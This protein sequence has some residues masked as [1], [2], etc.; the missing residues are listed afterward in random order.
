MEMDMNEAEKVDETS[1]GGLMV[2]GKVRTPCTLITIN[3]EG[4]VFDIYVMPDGGN[5]FLAMDE[6]LAWTYVEHVVADPDID[7]EVTAKHAVQQ[8][9][10]EHLRTPQKLTGPRT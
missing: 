5:V 9:L 6:E 4:R 2:T 7:P 10:R 1:A 8:V 3:Y